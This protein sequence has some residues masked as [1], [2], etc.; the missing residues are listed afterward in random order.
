MNWSTIW[1]K[2]RPVASRLLA[3]PV[4]AALTWLTAKYTIE[5]DAQTRA[6]YT[7]QIVD[8]ILQIVAEFTTIY[9]ATHR[10]GSVFLNPTDAASPKVAKAATALPGHGERTT[11]GARLDA[12]AQAVGPKPTI[13]NAVPIPRPDF[14]KPEPVVVAD[15]TKPAAKKR[16]PRKKKEPSDVVK[17][18][19]ETDIKPDE[20]AR[21]FQDFT[22]TATDLPRTIAPRPRLADDDKGVL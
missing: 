2:V 18:R 15:V 6:A 5:L 21:G 19:R 14:A 4:A 17:L 11:L 8:A 22:P 16:A 10:I 7:K 13:T 20:S 1:E 9:F 3:I 12:A